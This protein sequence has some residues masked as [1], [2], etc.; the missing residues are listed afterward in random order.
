MGPKLVH[1]RAYV[2]H[3]YGKWEDVISHLRSW[4]NR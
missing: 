4:P 1:V 3:R 2:R